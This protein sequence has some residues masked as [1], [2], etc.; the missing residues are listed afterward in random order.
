[1]IMIYLWHSI[2]SAIRALTRVLGSQSVCNIFGSVFQKFLPRHT[3]LLKN[4]L[5]FSVIVFSLHF[6][7]CPRY[8]VQDISFPSSLSLIHSLLI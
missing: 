1:M 5:F 3:H 8:V 6:L 2:L 4:D 7:L